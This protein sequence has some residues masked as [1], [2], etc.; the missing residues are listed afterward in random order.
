MTRR[1]TRQEVA[2]GA[3]VRMTSWQGLQPH[4]EIRVKGKPGQRSRY[5]FLAFVQNVESGECFVEVLGGRVGRDG[6]TQRNVRMF[7]PE[8]CSRPPRRR[9]RRRNAEATAAQL[10]FEDLLSEAIEIR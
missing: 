5:E 9:G 1:T 7:P 3:L 8:R 4:D 6:T 10:S 2:R